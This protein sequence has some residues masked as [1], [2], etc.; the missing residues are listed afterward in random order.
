MFDD[1]TEN[2]ALTKCQMHRHSALV[3]YPA[4]ACLGIVYANCSEGVEFG[5]H[6]HVALL[7][8]LRSMAIRK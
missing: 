4:R 1:R 7:L 5:K 2:K 8:Q 3:F 6:V